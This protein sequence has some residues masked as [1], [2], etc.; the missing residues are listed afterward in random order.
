MTS[1]GIVPELFCKLQLGLA[2]LAHMLQM[3]AQMGHHPPQLVTDF[4]LGM[5]EMVYQVSGAII[6]L[7]IEFL[8]R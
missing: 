7:D 8:E 3:V 2:Q 5:M 1:H 6:L 4:V